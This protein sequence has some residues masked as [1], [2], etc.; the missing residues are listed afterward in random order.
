MLIKNIESGSSGNSTIIGC[1]KTYII[2]DLGI[3]YKKLLEELGNLKVK[4]RKNILY[5]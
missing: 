4:S 5:L 3:T 1:N 2:I